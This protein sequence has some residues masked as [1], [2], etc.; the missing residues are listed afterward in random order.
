[1]VGSSAILVHSIKICKPT[2]R[3]HNQTLGNPALTARTGDI[4]VLRYQEN[5]YITLPQNNPPGKIDVSTIYVY[6][7]TSSTDMLADV[8]MVWNA[9]GTGGDRGGQLL[10]TRSF[11]DGRLAPRMSWE[12]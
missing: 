10:T 3:T 12:L 2:Q 1:M 7:T 6:G 9:Q 5:G 4:V 11:D 8:H